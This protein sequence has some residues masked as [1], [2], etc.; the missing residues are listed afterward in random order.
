VSQL[1]VQIYTDPACVRM[2]AHFGRAYAHAD[3]SQVRA[4]PSKPM[5]KEDRRGLRVVAA[6]A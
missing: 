1:F 4:I 6:L 2:H 3:L 5:A